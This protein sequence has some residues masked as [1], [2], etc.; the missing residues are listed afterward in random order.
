MIELE[1]AILS[2]LKPIESPLGTGAYDYETCLTQ[3]FGSFSK[4]E[5]QPFTDQLTGAALSVPYYLHTCTNF[6]RF[7]ANIRSS[8][9]KAFKSV[10]N[11]I[12]LD[13]L[14]QMDRKRLFK[15]FSILLE[16]FNN[17][18]H[19]APDRDPL[20]PGANFH[21]RAHW[22]AYLLYFS[23]IYD[24]YRGK[25]TAISDFQEQEV[26]GYILTEHQGKELWRRD[27]Q[28]CNPIYL[29]NELF[30][31]AFFGRPKPLV[32]YHGDLHEPITTKLMIQCYWGLAEIILKHHVDPNGTKMRLKRLA[33]HE[34]YAVAKMGLYT[35][36]VLINQYNVTILAP[37]LLYIIELALNGPLPSSRDYNRDVYDQE[38]LYPPFRFYKICN[39]IPKDFAV[40]TSQGADQE[41]VARFFAEMKK[42]VQVI[43]HLDLYSLSIPN[44]EANILRSL[45]AEEVENFDWYQ[46][47]LSLSSYSSYRILGRY[48]SVTEY[49]MSLLFSSYGKP[50]MID[51]EFSPISI[52]RDA[53]MSVFS[54]FHWQLNGPEKSFNRTRAFMRLQT[55]SFARTSFMTQ[56]G[57][58]QLLPYS[59]PDEILFN[60]WL[61]VEKS[62][63]RKLCLPWL[64]R[65]TD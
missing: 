39:S 14:P 58:P 15:D 49:L 54:L 32:H 50:S 56:K 23:S 24:P 25:E 2:A 65:E 29:D 63:Y 64:L 40:L 46:W 5:R 6:G 13:S 22:R 35:L 37:T 43:H 10:S 57:E 59:V 7:Q 61:G 3:F 18:G 9:D 27:G 41:N 44:L 51:L 53:Y 8:R 12:Q 26:L 34:C 20:T 47:Y 42:A 60:R 38:Q 4:I 11:L 19:P 55:A 52:D 36:N 62:T 1:S 17:L 30:L 45:D 31:T 16:D 33:E 48:S 21:L 28:S